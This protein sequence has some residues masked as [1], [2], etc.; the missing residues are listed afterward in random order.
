MNALYNKTEARAKLDTAIEQS[1]TFL[2]A[3]KDVAVQ[4]LSTLDVERLAVQPT[5]R[6]NPVWQIGPVS[7]AGEVEE[8]FAFHMQGILVKSSLTPGA[9]ERLP[10]DRGINTSQGVTLI[11]LGSPLFSEAV[12]KLHEIHALYCRYFPPNSM[13]KW[14][15]ADSTETTLKAS[16]RFFTSVEDEPDAVSINFSTGVDPLHKL[17]RF[18]GDELVHTS[19]NV[20][21]YRKR[22]NNGEEAN[23]LEVAYPGTFRIGDVVEIDASVIAFKTSNRQNEIKMHCNLNGLTLLDATFSKAMEEGKR[24][25]VVAPAPAKATLRRKNPY[26]DEDGQGG[27]RARDKA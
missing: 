6:V 22:I 11:G 26:E 17:D 7:E 23:T 3:R 12:G 2:L 21:R 27:K 8:E 9:I 4:H 5:G 10:I 25:A 15:D 14:T 1:K 19:A 18:I 20:V 13:S 24:N 16:N